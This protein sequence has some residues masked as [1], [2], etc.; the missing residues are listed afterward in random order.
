VRAIGVRRKGGPVLVIDLV[1]DETARD[2]REDEH[3]DCHLRIGKLPTHLPV[4]DRQSH[5]LRALRRIACGDA[6]D[7]S[8]EHVRR[9]QQPCLPPQEEAQPV[10]D[11]KQHDNSVKAAVQ[12]GNV[13]VKVFP[14]S[15]VPGEAVSFAG[16]GLGIQ[17]DG[18]YGDGGLKVK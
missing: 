17:C 5:L 13:R 1:L 18:G 6:S 8:S 3:S 16:S 12:L 15:F 4:S 11:T 7:T 14:E 9:E 2:G 10:R